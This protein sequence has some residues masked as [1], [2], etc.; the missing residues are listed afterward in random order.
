M[1]RTRS[2]SCASARAVR[3]V[4]ARPWRLTVTLAPLFASPCAGQYSYVMIWHAG[5]KG[6]PYRPDHAHWT[7]RWGYLPSAVRTVWQT[8]LQEVP[9]PGPRP[10]ALLVRVLLGVPPAHQQLLRRQESA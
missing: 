9:A 6:T 8:N 3:R 5:S 1:M 2:G 4:S 10:R 7:P